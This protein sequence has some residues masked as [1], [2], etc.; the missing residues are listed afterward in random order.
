MLLLLIIIYPI[1]P[2]WNFK[3]FFLGFSNIFVTKK[4][5]GISGLLK[6]YFKFYKSIVSQSIEKLVTIYCWRFRK[7]QSLPNQ[8]AKPVGTNCPSVYS[9]KS[10]VWKW[11]SNSRQQDEA[12]NKNNTYQTITIALVRKPSFCSA[13]VLA[14]I[15]LSLTV[16]VV[17]SWLGSYCIVFIVFF[18]IV[19]VKIYARIYTHTHMHIHMKLKF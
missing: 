9:S 7:F 19:E 17:I 4:Y 11:Q 1:N 12:W 3:I 6:R 8:S 5:F 16:N 2:F 10:G 13:S 14:K 18:I 15:L